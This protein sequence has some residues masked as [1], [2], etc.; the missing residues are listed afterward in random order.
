MLLGVKADNS[1]L[2]IGS[3]EVDRG[4]EEENSLPS[5]LSDWLPPRS[6][7]FV[8]L[9]STGVWLPLRGERW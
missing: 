5:A 9:T 8:E 3:G 6:P 2:L 1:L 4:I 7:E